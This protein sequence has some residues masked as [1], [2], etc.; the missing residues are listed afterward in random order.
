MRTS[1]NTKMTCPECKHEFAI[2]KG[3]LINNEEEV[4][5]QINAEV[6]KV[7]QAERAKIESDNEIKEKDTANKLKELSENYEQLR[8]EHLKALSSKRES[9][10]KVKEA[11][12]V[13][14]KQVNDKLEKL[15]SEIAEKLEEKYASRLAQ[16]DK[17]LSDLDKELTASQNRIHQGSQQ[18]QGEAA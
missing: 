5:K 6:E 14:E 16:K 7:L 3:L 2:E 17:K 10:Q 12:L 18:L 11:D 8:T 15:E 13:I 1:N 9:D 4:Q